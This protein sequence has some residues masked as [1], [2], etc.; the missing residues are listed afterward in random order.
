MLGR[1]LECERS[2]GDGG[3]SDCSS[4]QSRQVFLIGRLEGLQVASGVDL[5]RSDESW[6]AF[7]DSSLSLFCLSSDRP[8]SQANEH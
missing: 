8:G 5:N 3:G 2:G 4:V 6:G 1:A 7:R